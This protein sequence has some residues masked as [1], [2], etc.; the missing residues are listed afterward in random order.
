[1]VGCGRY[2]LVD[3]ALVHNSQKNHPYG[4]NH[5]LSSQDYEA[6]TQS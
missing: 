6:K 2:H 3:D 1:V 4:K 5:R